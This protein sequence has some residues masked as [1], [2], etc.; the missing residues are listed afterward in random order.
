DEV[1][2]IAFG[3]H[4][5]LHSAP[6]NFITSSGNGALGETRMTI[7]GEGNVG[8]GTNNP[9]AKLHVMGSG[10]YTAFQMQDGSEGINKV[11]I[12]DADGKAT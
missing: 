12:S 3:T 10:Q 5:T 9:D 1:N 8:I 2:S 4:A 11:L 6:I 7:T